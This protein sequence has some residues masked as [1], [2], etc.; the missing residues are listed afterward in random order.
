MLGQ[1]LWPP[2][3]SARPV[4]RAAGVWEKQYGS[5]EGLRETRG[6]KAQPRQGLRRLP[7]GTSLQSGSPWRKRE[8]E[9]GWPTVKVT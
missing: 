3:V 8:C 2:R 9:E 4:L 6:G 7:S 5:G 1:E